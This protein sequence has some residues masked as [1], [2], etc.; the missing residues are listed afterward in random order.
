METYTK[1][2]FLPPLIISALV[3]AEGLCA[4]S[5]FVLPYYTLE[6]SILNLILALQSMY[7]VDTVSPIKFVLACI[8]ITSLMQRGTL[9]LLLV[10]PNRVK[11]SS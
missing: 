8:A 1:S 6:F 2:G 9:M 7:V 10:T 4:F 5:F 11:I 3:A